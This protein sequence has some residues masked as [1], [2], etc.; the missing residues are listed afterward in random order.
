MTAS[1]QSPPAFAQTNLQLYRQL[2]ASG[3]ASQDLAHVRAAY[4]LA[5][6]L[7]AGRFRASGK[8]FLCHVVGVSSFVAALG[9]RAEVVAGGLVHSVYA[10]GNFRDSAQGVTDERRQT[11]TRALG[12]TIEEIAFEYHRTPWP[13]LLRQAARGP[14][15]L[16]QSARALVLLKLGDIYDDCADGSCAIAPGKRLDFDLPHDPDGRRTVINAARALWG[17]PLVG[18]FE[19]LFREVDSNSHEPALESNAKGSYALR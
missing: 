19:R 18:V 8:P 7:F 6:E 16:A 13:A 5:C 17:P 9:A 4:E 3:F 14:E 1:D 2:Q 15:G 12:E 11:L 10:Q